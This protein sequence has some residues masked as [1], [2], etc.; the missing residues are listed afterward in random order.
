[1]LINGTC[2]AESFYRQGKFE[3]A[4][5]YFRVS[6]NLR[7]IVYDEEKTKAIDEV[8]QKYQAVERKKQ[9]ELLTAE[10]A[11]SEARSERDAW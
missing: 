6:Y 1:M 11:A 2:P 5:Y 10:N 9:I 4:A 8:S 7:S 3:R